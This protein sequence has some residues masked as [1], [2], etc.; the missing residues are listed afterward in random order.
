MADLG[1]TA[2]RSPVDKTRFLTLGQFKVQAAGKPLAFQS[3]AQRPLQLLKVLIALGAES[4]AIEQLTESLWPDSE[5]DRAYGAFT[6]TLRRLRELIGHDRPVLRAGRLSLNP[7]TC[8]ID[9][10]EYVSE[11]SQSMRS[12]QAGD[13]RQASVRLSAALE[14]YR[15]PF[16]PGDFD[17]GEILSARAQLHAMFLRAVETHGERYQA[18]GKVDE[19]MALYRR[20]IEIDDQAEPLYQRLLRCLLAN[21][22]L[23]EGVSLYQRCRQ[24]LQATAGASPSHE[25]E[26]I[27]QALL[28]A[29]QESAPGGSA[30]NFMNPS[31]H[32]RFDT[33]DRK[34]LEQAAP[35]L[36]ENDSSAANMAER[37]VATVVCF[38]FILPDSN[39]AVLDPEELHA[40]SVGL[41]EQAEHAVKEHGGRFVRLAGSSA[42]AW[43]GLPNAHDD[44][45]QRAVK[46]ALACRSRLAQ[47]AASHPGQSTVGV[48]VGVATGMFVTD[49]RNARLEQETVGRP[50]DRA[51]ALA[52]SAQSAQILSDRE[53]WNAV[54]E[55][56]AAARVVAPLKGAPGAAGSVEILQPLEVESR[57]DAA[58]R[59]GLSP[60]TGRE[61]ELQ[62]LQHFLRISSGGEG[63]FVSIVGEAGIG[64]SRLLYEF[65]ESV[66]GARVRIIEGRCQSYGAAT[67]Y[68]PV[69]EAI[70][71]SIDLVNPLQADRMHD[72]AC[73]NIRSISP[74]LEQYLPHLLHLLSIPSER[75]SLPVTLQGVARR[76]ELEDAFSQLIASLSR[77]KPVVLIFEDWHWADEASD[78]ALHALITKLGA[79][80]ILLLV[81]YRP[82]SPQKWQQADGHRM[83]SLLPLDGYHT[84]RMLRSTLKAEDLPEGLVESIHARTQGNA[85]FVEEMAHA[86]LDEQA[87]EVLGDKGNGGPRLEFIGLPATIRAVIQTRVD[88]L[89]NGD[90]DVLKFASAIGQEFES[91]ILEGLLGNPGLVSGAVARLTSR[92][93]IRPVRSPLQGL[94]QFKHVLTQEVTYDTLLLSQRRDLHGRIGGLIEAL[95]SD[96]LEQ[97][98]EVLAN[99]F[100]KSENLDKAVEY[101]RMAGDKAVRQSSLEAARG[102][103]ARALNLLGPSNSEAHR[104]ERAIDLAHQLAS[105]SEYS[106]SKQVIEALNAA[107]ISSAELGDELR[108][109]TTVYWIGRL[110]YILG[111]LPEALSCFENAMG[112]ADQIGNDRLKGRSLS[113]L[114]R[115]CVY[116]AEHHRGIGYLTNATQIM[117]KAGEIEEIAYSSHVLGL[118]HGMLGEFEKALQCADNGLRIAIDRKLISRQPMAQIQLAWLR[119]LRGEFAKG[120]KTIDGA[121]SITQRAGDTYSLSIGSIVEGWLRFMSGEQVAG[122]RLMTQGTKG[123]ESLGSRMALTQWYGLL[124]EALALVGDFGEARHYAELGISI[125]KG[126][127]RHGE[128]ISHRAMAIVAAKQDKNDFGAADEWMDASIAIAGQLQERPYEAISHLRYAEMLKLRGDEDHARFHVTEA[129]NHFERMGMVGWLPFLTLSP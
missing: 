78:A 121:R 63:R 41:N 12:L 120:L 117:E 89:E 87:L 54:R 105:I 9:A 23:T 96:Q 91:A 114:G 119:G 46:A 11:I 13:S 47:K 35:R 38:R 67:P 125:A 56:F 115:S 73:S 36:S 20:G 2:A 49:A 6:I 70:R 81:A 72:A 37:R 116:T 57:F 26:S 109:A 79:F 32:T 82:D 123:V 52:T 3:K 33:L 24:L 45:P 64:K 128:C 85:L 50:V 4:V 110:H 14:L 19:A 15:G 8:W 122:I 30:P 58:R 7:D 16:L 21:S 53:T 112:L 75:H 51:I 66:D 97:F 55:F 98:C 18:Q 17:S 103:Y 27:Y 83:L 1:S 59:R 107:R 29:Q 74:D 10:V 108:L 88:R 104:A 34:H 77:H 40:L 31:V 65:R 76:H 86:L 113:A 100:S 22:R 84:G 44:D 92:D 124:A 99:H 42:L 68:L 62:T 111:E 48:G 118:H 25:T 69:L 71:Q 43:F 28:K 101:L 127:Q 39:T 102:Y 61:W 60:F 80:P 126:G 90:R 106:P 94:F 5:G 93:L 95:H 129:H